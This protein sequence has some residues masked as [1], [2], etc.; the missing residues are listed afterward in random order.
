MSSE[1]KEINLRRLKE[2]LGDQK[3]LNEL[4]NEQLMFILHPLKQG[5]HL[6]A[7]P[8][9]GKTQCVGIKLSYHA[10]Q[11]KN[12]SRGMAVLSFTK[13]AA[14]E[15][16][17]RANLFSREEV[18]STPH[19]V[20]TFDS[21]IHSFLFNP[22]GHTVTAFEGIDGDFSHRLIQH[23]S[24]APFLNHYITMLPAGP[25]F[26]TINITDFS[27]GVDGTPVWTGKGEK[28]F[29]IQEHWRLKSKKIEFA[30]KGFVTYADI[31]YWCLKL[32]Q[33][34]K[35][36]LALL[37][38]RFPCIIIDECQDLSKIQ[39]AILNELFQAGTILHLIGDK[40]QAI[41][42]FRKVDPLL[43]EKQI[44][45]WNLYRLELTKNFR[46]SQTICD[47]AAK[48]KGRPQM[49]ANHSGNENSCLLW[50]YEI[51][52]LSNIQHAF[53]NMLEQCAIKPENAVIVARGHKVLK[54]IKGDYITG[55]RSFS[56][57]IATALYHWTVLNKTGASMTQAI[58]L[59]SKVIRDLAY[60]GKSNQHFIPFP[61]GFT[62]VDWRR[63]IVKILDECRD[64]AFFLH[65]SQ[66]ATWSVWINS[67][68]KPK[69][70]RLWP[71]FAGHTHTYDDSK[72]RI[73]AASGFA[74]KLVFNG[75]FL[76]DKGKGIKLE[77]IH[78]I[79]GDTYDAT[80]L[81]S[82]P[83]KQSKG[84]HYEH[85]MENFESE[86]N[87]FA[88]VACTRPRHLLIIATPKLKKTSREAF[89][90]LGITPST[91]TP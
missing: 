54:L 75:N 56:Y 28:I 26:T 13:I 33:T 50:E 48:L 8:G 42:E 15:I 11:W 69:L 49:I 25:I 78:G 51:D 35:D 1:Q 31:E 53:Q 45:L 4:T 74:D 86:Y 52:N 61:D 67:Y 64:I 57:D 72:N 3:S 82:A 7:C 90:N 91:M 23:D 41:Y 38:R 89:I 43:V 80:L 71:T 65:N 83:T 20:G 68:L 39:I 10:A 60:D 70:K 59:C 77:T 73:K 55:E 44:V 16:K 24:R 62:A 88:Y 58:D 2:V 21:W 81:V 37:T 22:F 27:F 40:D 14:K 66:P 46:C 63:L 34:R 32:L 47:L 76:A 85:W 5:T 9:S 17:E 18:I 6:S 87:R 84:G 12:R 29:P 30:K 19:F 36:I 79:K